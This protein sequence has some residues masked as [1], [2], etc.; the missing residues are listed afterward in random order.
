M[1]PVRKELLWKYETG[2][3]EIVKWTITL[4]LK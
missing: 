2:S 1:Q 4:V 3:K